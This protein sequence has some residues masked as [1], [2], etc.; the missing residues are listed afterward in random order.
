MEKI[1][2]MVVGDLLPLYCDDVCSG[3]S[4]EIVEAHLQTCPKCSEMLQKMRMEYRLSNEEEQKQEEM[5]KNMASTWQRSVKTSFRRGALIALCV[6]LLLAGGYYA[7]TR[8]I[9]ISVPLSVTEAAVGNITDEN[10]EV[11]LKVTD[12]KKVHA[13]TMENTEDGKCFIALKRGVIP[14]GNGGGEAWVGEWSVPKTGVT[15]SGERISIRE[16]YCG[17]EDGNF[18]IWQSE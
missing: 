16:I 18:L 7:L 1:T 14:Q 2:C 12:G 8:M 3:D 11:F 4:R 9:L 15:D 13:A 6:C 17:T 10:V 5:V